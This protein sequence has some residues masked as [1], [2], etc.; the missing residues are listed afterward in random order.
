[1]KVKRTKVHAWLVYWPSSHSVY[2]GQH[3]RQVFQLYQFVSGYISIWF[4]NYFLFRAVRSLIIGN[5]KLHFLP[6]STWWLFKLPLRIWHITQFGQL[7]VGSH[8]TWL[9]DFTI[10]WSCYFGRF[11]VP[12]NSSKP[13]SF[14]WLSETASMLFTTHNRQKMFVCTTYC[15]EIRFS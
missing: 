4:C 6:R 1:M 10:L 2:T 8:W 7:H 5:I 11:C 14:P 3:W 15:S 12:R 13:F 9:S